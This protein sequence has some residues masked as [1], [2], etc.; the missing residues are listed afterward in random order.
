M[1][2][3]NTWV[4]A[5]LL[6]MALPPAAQA[7][8]QL[9]SDKGCYNC[10]GAHRRGDAPSIERLSSRLSRLKGDEAALQKFVEQYRRGE[11]LNHIDTHQHLS[12]ASAQA[13]I[14]W[15]AEGAK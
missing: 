15:L 13:L 2:Y 11:L 5:L 1:R 3:R 10:H 4:G 7:S 8:A 6:A 14:R 9:A 12:Q